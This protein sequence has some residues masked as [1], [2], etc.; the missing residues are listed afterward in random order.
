MVG[1]LNFG[2]IDDVSFLRVVVFICVDNGY[3]VNFDVNLILE[4][5]KLV[6]NL[7]IRN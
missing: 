2:V 6:L 1:F 7:F 4:Y 5:E 3:D